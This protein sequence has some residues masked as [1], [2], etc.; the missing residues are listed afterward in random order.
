MK[1]KMSADAARTDS[2]KRDVNKVSLKPKTESLKKQYHKTKNVC[3]VTFTL[4][5]E[6]AADAK[7]VTIVGDFNK[8]N[9]TENKM[10][11]LK[12]RGLHAYA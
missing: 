10:K 6:A 9:I 12:K 2:N 5:K 1:K 7:S 11:K 3:K 4:P 8:W